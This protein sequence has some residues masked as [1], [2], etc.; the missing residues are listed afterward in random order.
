MLS[1]LVKPF[2]S[3]G[4]GKNCSRDFVIRITCVQ[5]FVRIISKMKKILIIESWME[6]TFNVLSNIFEEENDEVRSLL[7]YREVPRSSALSLLFK[8]KKKYSAFIPKAMHSMTKY[9][10]DL[11]FKEILN[12]KDP[13]VH[14]DFIPESDAIFKS[15][16]YEGL[17]L[18]GSSNFTNMGFDI[19]VKALVKEET[20]LCESFIYPKC[21]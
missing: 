20:A 8:C 7:P 19:F 12:R 4:F 14:F 2:S 3:E 16:T 18:F 10:S 21:T 11:I 6:N 13:F 5:Y 15:I 17:K 1:E 9:D